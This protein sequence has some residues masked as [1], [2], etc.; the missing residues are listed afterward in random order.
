MVPSERRL[1]EPVRWTTV[2][3]TSPDAEAVAAILGWPKH[4]EDKRDNDSDVAKPEPDFEIPQAER[5]VGC[6][7]PGG[8]RDS[9]P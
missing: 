8:N 1:L 7:D 4:K 9:A 5:D 2:S 3:T 6:I